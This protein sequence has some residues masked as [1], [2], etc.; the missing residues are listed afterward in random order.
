MA[1]I[2]ARQWGVVDIDDLRSCGLTREAI[3]WRIEN[4]RL[5]PLYRGVYAVGHPTISLRGRCLAAVRACGPGAVIS[6]FT[7]AFLWGMLEPFTRYP[8]VTAPKPRKHPTINTHESKNLDATTLHGIP[9]TTPIQTLIH[10][11]AI[12]PFKTLRRAVNEAL[13]RRLITPQQLITTRHR[14]A[15]NL[16]QTLATAAPTRSDNENLALHLLHEAGIEK[17]LVNPRVSGTNKIPDFLWP[18]RNLILEADSWRYHDHPLARADDRDKQRILEGL[19][20]TVIRTTWREMTTRPDCMLARVQRE[21]TR[22]D[23]PA[24]LVLRSA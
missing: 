20:F 2:A 23:P 1:E 5:H 17:P 4:G 18:D 21:L 7:A 12:V 14:G 6:H 24:A 3:S 8:D 11:S 19:G 22:V 13:N 15:K 16:R 10:L 9:I